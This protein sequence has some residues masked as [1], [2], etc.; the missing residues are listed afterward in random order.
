MAKPSN[1]WTDE[2]KAYLRRE[3]PTYKV[4][5]VVVE[6]M[7]ALAGPLVTGP[8]ISTY[9]RQTLGLHRPSDFC[10]VVGRGRTMERA[11]AA[12]EAMS[13]YSGP[14][15]SAIRGKPGVWVPPVGRTVQQIEVIAQDM[16]YVYTGIAD[17][18]AFNKHRVA[19]GYPPLAV[20][21]PKREGAAPLP[22][23][24]LAGVP[25]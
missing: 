11:V 16:A 15:L 9:A 22:S 10:D 14:D 17:L 21:F 2:R 6:E 5:S 12:L 1:R 4:R 13:P 18:P 25:R 23:A 3:W 7:N 20:T 8:Q 19:R 24:F